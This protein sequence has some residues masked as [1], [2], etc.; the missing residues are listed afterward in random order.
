MKRLR[1]LMVYLLVV[2]GMFNV[3][4]WLNDIQE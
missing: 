2:V 4:L 1:L 3:G